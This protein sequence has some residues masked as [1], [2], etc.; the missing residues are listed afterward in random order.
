MASSQAFATLQAA[1]LPELQRLQRRQS[2]ALD[3]LRQDSAVMQKLL[4]KLDVSSASS[5]LGAPSAP[6]APSA[7]ASSSTTI[8]THP[9]VV[10]LRCHASRAIDAALAEVAPFDASALLRALPHTKA[11]LR[12]VIHSLRDAA[13]LLQAP[14]GPSLSQLGQAYD[15][16]RLARDRCKTNESLYKLVKHAAL[17]T[18]ELFVIQRFSSLS[19][20]A[21]S[22]GLDDLKRHV[23]NVLRRPLDTEL[24][25]ELSL[26]YSTVQNLGERRAEFEQSRRLPALPVRVSGVDDKLDGLYRFVKIVEGHSVYKNESNHHGVTIGFYGRWQM[27]DSVSDEILSTCSPRTEATDVHPPCG[28]QNQWHHNDELLSQGFVATQVPY[29]EI[30]DLI[31]RKTCENS[32]QQ[33]ELFAVY[34]YCRH[35]NSYISKQKTKQKPRRGAKGSALPESLA[36]GRS[37]SRTKTRCCSSPPMSWKGEP[38]YIAQPDP[39]PRTSSLSLAGRGPSL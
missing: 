13:A 27:R 33:E 21:T 16:V 6:P 1:S 28:P 11:M 7:L 5:G 22:M 4:V 38:A 8:G 30:E 35:H 39:V 3:E 19:P 37:S 10:V 32:D 31:F 25:A 24:C 36:G 34:E 17:L 20:C 2:E 12:T 23:E 14:P 29:N 15:L 26:S 9:G 18:R